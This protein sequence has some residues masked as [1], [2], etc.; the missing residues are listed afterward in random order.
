MENERYKINPIE[1]N[2]D[3]GGGDDEDS[4]DEFN[5]HKQPR[6]RRYRKLSGSG[7]HIEEMYSH[8]ELHHANIEHS[9]N[10]ANGADASYASD[11][12]IESYGS[13]GQ[14]MIGSDQEELLEFR[15]LNKDLLD[16]MKGKIAFKFGAR[17]SDEFQGP[18][19]I[20]GGFEIPQQFH[21]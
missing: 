6:R 19:Y 3:G 13:Q 11:R 15:Q 1:A 8:G 12:S 20:V 9:V 2:D 14:E 5:D 17:L 18:P 16:Q 21:N 10:Q 4:V 7:V